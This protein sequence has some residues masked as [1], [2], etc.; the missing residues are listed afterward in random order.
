MLDYLYHIVSQILHCSYRDAYYICLLCRSLP[1]RIHSETLLVS[2]QIP[3]FSMPY[4]II[5]FV[6]T[7][8]AI[9]FGSLFNLTTKT[10]QPMNEDDKKSIVSKLRSKIKSLL[11]KSTAS[12]SKLNYILDH[13]KCCD[14]NKLCMLCNIM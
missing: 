2:H 7:A 11:Q 14:C 8:V 5:C 1:V 10:L 12:K 9:G 3:D 6:S 13:D 4:N